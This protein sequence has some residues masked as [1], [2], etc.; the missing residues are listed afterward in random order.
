MRCIDGLGRVVFGRVVFAP[1]AGRAYV[2][3]CSTS[4]TN[5]GHTGGG[6]TEVHKKN[7]VL[8]GEVKNGVK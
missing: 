4:R 1:E 8:V 3:F 6:N 7:G 5:R 2:V